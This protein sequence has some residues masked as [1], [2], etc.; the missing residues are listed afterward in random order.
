MSAVLTLPATPGVHLQ[1][2]D[3]G[4]EGSVVLRTDIVGFAGFAERGPIGPAVAIETMRQ[5][6]AV[7]GTY[8]P[9]AELAYAVGPSSR[10]AAAAAAL[11]VSLQQATLAGAAP[12]AIDILD[13]SRQSRLC[14]C[15]LQLRQLRQCRADVSVRALARGDSRSRCRAQTRPEA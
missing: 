8:L 9:G 7:F 10:T 14:S 12:A 3:P 11:C 5:F 15:R 6:A 1:R 13:S 4:R 2:S